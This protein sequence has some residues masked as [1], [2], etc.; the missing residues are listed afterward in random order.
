MYVKCAFNYI[1]CG[2]NGSVRLEVIFMTAEKCFTCA[3]E[4]LDGTKVTVVK[5]KGVES[6]ILA[7]KK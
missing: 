4:L 6:F 5:S 2:L 7:S 3:T 1:L